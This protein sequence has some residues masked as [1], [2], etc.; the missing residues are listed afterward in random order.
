MNTPSVVL[1]GYPPILIWPGGYPGRVPPCHQGT[2]QQGTP[3]QGTPLPG[4]PPPGYPPPGYPPA[5][6]GR[7][8]PWAGPG[9]VPPTGCPMAFWEMLQSIMRY[10]YPPPGVDKL[11]KWNYYLP[12]ILRTWVVKTRKSYVNT[13]GIPKVAYQVLHLLPEVGYPLWPGP[14]GGYLRWGT[15]P[16]GVPPLSGLTWGTWGGVPLG[17]GTPWPGPMGVP[18]VGYSLAGVLPGR[19]TPHLDLAGVPPPPIRPGW[20]I[21]PHLDL[22]GVSPSR[23]GQTRVKT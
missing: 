10:G 5:G 6:P 7:V 20:G 13:R 16:A 17:R 23:C 11:T 8:P 4:Y 18:K 19:G 1:T 9:R 22:A 15:P 14:M 12:I 3:C 21:P 2:P